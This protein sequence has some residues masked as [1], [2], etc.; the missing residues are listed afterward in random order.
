MMSSSAERDARMCVCV[1]AAKRHRGRQR[2]RLRLIELESRMSQSANATRAVRVARV[3]ARFLVHIC[4]T[5]S[6][7][8]SIGDSRACRC[9]AIA[10]FQTPARIR[11]SLL[12]LQRRGSAKKSR[13]L[14]F[15]IARNCKHFLQFICYV[16]PRR[17]AS[18]NAVSLKFDRNKLAS[19]RI[20]ATR[21]VSR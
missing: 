10:F 14:G 4:R 20:R 16:N 15:R 8:K 7:R 19:T 9:A 21:Y 12:R 11:V 2:A 13:H 18:G 17:Q 3:R 6:Q 1:R 5:M